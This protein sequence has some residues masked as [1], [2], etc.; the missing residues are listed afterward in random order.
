MQR[1]CPQGIIDLRKYQMNVKGIKVV[2]FQ[3][4]EK[5]ESL[6]PCLRDFKHC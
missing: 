1:T 4:W 3:W 5:H 2:F 6:F